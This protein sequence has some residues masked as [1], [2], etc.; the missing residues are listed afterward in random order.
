MTRSVRFREGRMRIVLPGTW[1]NIPLDDEETAVEHVRRL[2]RRQV[3]KA[4]RL[5]R[6]RREATQEVVGNVRAA[7]SAGVHTYLMSLELLP[8]VPFPAVILAMDEE[9]PAASAEARAAGDG[10]AALRAGFPTGEVEPQRNGPVARVVEMTQGSTGEGDDVLTMRLEYHIPYPDGSRLLMA[11]VNVPGIPSAEPFATLFDE[12][13]DS[14]TFMEQDGEE[15][16]GQQAVADAAPG[17]G[18][19]AAGPARAAM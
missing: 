6:A 15:Q 9:W 16:E 4:D 3:G 18:D 8:G 13:L 1:A 19:P 10:A 2:V 17:A 7:M 11:R 5:A 14:I 12:I